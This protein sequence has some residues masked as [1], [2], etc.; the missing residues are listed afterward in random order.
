[1][2]ILGLSILVLV[3]LGCDD[4]QDVFSQLNEPPSIWV[5]KPSGGGELE[6]DTVKLGFP[7]SRRFEYRHSGGTPLLDYAADEGAGVSLN[8]GDRLLRMNPTEEGSYS[9]ALGITDS[10]RERGE[11]SLTLYAFSNW[12]PVAVLELTYE[13]SNTV[14]ID[15][16]ASYDADARFGGEVV[17]YEYEILGGV[18]PSA[19]STLRFAYGTPGTKR[20]GVRVRDNNDVWSSWSIKEI[21]F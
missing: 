8:E 6:R 5:V 18:Y 16:T 15:A 7:V 2:R 9:V 19:M 17:G 14:L 21:T 13:G 20:I 11:Y 1:M 3:A 12:K 10:F 4:R